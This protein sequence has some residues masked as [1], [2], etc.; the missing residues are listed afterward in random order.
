MIER[1]E[2]D[3][4][5]ATVFD[6]CSVQANAPLSV[7]DMGLVLGV[8]V[9]GDGVVSLRIR[10]T[11]QWCTM[12]GS[13]MQGIEDRVG[14]VPGVREVRIDI[15]RETMWSEAE[16]TPRGKDILYGV[17]A[18]SRAAVPVRRQQWKERLQPAAKD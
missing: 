9:Q 2:I 14:A 18:R 10:P 5:L 3:A 8:E 12:I 17:R 7:V 15:D 11:S 16:L 6:P 1:A 4:A 13:I